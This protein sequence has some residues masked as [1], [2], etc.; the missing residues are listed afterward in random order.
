MNGLELLDHIAV[1][2]NSL[3]KPTS[4]RSVK[5]KAEEIVSRF[6]NTPINLEDYGY[7]D[8]SEILTEFEDGD[9]HLIGLLIKEIGVKLDL[10]FLMFIA[11]FN[12]GLVFLEFEN[13]PKSSL[14]SYMKADQLWFDA[15]SEQYYCGNI[16]LAHIHLAQWDQAIEKLKR[17]LELAR[18]RGDDESLG[19]YFQNMGVALRG[20]GELFDA[21]DCYEKAFEISRGLGDHYL[22]IRKKNLDEIEKD[23]WKY[24]HGLHTEGCKIIVGGQ[25]GILALP[26]CPDWIAKAKPYLVRPSGLYQKIQEFLNS[27][28]VKLRKFL[29]NRLV[30]EPKHSTSHSVKQFRPGDRFTNKYRV[31]KVMQGVMGIV[32]LLEDLER[33]SITHPQFVCAKTFYPKFMS[34]EAKSRFF[35]EVE[36]WLLLGRYEHVV[37]AYDYGE[38]E[39]QPYAY[40]QYADGGSL[41]DLHKKGFDPQD[42]TEDFLK[43][44]FFSYGLALGMKKI[45]DRL[46]IPHGDLH[47]GN[48]L[49]AENG[50]LIKITDFGV[51]AAITGQQRDVRQDI[52]QF[53]RVLWCLFTGLEDGKEKIT[54][55]IDHHHWIG[56][57]VRKLILDS[58]KPSTDEGSL[59]FGSAAKRINEYYCDLTGESLISP[60]DFLEEKRLEIM[61]DVQKALG[62]ITI[63]EGPGTISIDEPDSSY[64]NR[65]AALS[66][67][68]KID[69]AFEN[70][71]IALKKLRTR[72]DSQEA[73][74]CWENF[75]ILLSRISDI[76]KRQK[77]EKKALKVWGRDEQPT[78]RNQGRDLMAI[79][80]IEGGDES[81]HISDL[82]AAIGQFRKE[83]PKKS[84]RAYQILQQLIPTPIYSSFGRIELASTL[85][86]ELTTSKF[87]GMKELELRSMELW[88]K[89]N[90]AF[91]L[92]ELGQLD[93]S[94]AESTSAETAARNLSDYISEYFRSHDDFNLD[95]A[96]PFDVAR[97]G[98]QAG[99]VRALASLYSGRPDLALECITRVQEFAEYGGDHF[100]FGIRDVIKSLIIAYSKPKQDWE[101]VLSQGEREVE[102]CEDFQMLDTCLAS[103]RAWRVRARLIASECFANSGNLQKAISAARAAKEILDEA[104]P[105]PIMQIRVQSRL[106]QCLLMSG[107]IEEAEEYVLRAFNGCIDFRI[108]DIEPEVSTDYALL[109]LHQLGTIDRPEL[110]RVKDDYLEMIENSI[111]RADERGLLLQKVRIMLALSEIHRTMGNSESARTW[112]ITA[113]QAA[114]SN[115]TDSRLEA[116]I[117]RSKKQISLIT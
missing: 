8:Y 22:A 67:L 64:I 68:G 105:N 101:S 42:S 108:G 94:I 18:L 111:T 32:Y 48:V 87:K 16:A 81:K 7:A 3:Q 33:K 103:G 109:K 45:Y 49:F 38:V 106:G 97:Y 53:G 116:L 34:T 65:A 9:Q 29:K 95:A 112:A 30:S 50:G 60:E 6:E 51:M 23:I 82:E 91:L 28:R 98:A 41:R 104:Y 24:E 39:G 113:K 79:T 74:I 99:L 89:T 117:L 110:M 21:K 78:H 47:P 2:W 27:L 31:K 5:R 10:S 20:K 54:N 40:V 70:F 100:L 102:D 19:I 36:L 96:N 59:F 69:E 76:N 90:Q 88:A 66:D 13:D 14:R 85:L 11:Y 15:L 46:N 75:Q 115:D 114:I 57:P 1:E 62:S 93:A 73:K 4:E 92:L 72:K 56:K 26:W 84:P 86:K 52:I 17:A 83:L 77:Y 35:K 25:M 58:M 61:G 71:L 63:L 80:N 55:N 37:W 44:I 12:D 43:A 107:R